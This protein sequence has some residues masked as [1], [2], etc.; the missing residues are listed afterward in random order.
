[1]G[2]LD[3][4]KKGEQPV[5]HYSDEVL[6]VV[7]WSKED[8]AWVGNF[9]SFEFGLGYSRT[10]APSV[11]VINYAREILNDSPFLASSLTEAKRAALLKRGVFYRD[12]IDSLIFDEIHFFV[13]K[14]E[15]RILADL[16][17]GKDYRLWRIE[18]TDRKCHG[19]GFDD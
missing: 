16:E 2:F 15:R 6:G 19:I 3:F 17:G 11:E 7:R 4:F 14:G 8:E 5:E 12:E 13:Q 9:D 1:M 18:Y 10:S